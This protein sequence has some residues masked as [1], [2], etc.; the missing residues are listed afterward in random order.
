MLTSSGVITH[1]CVQIS[2]TAWL[3]GTQQKVCT[4]WRSSACFQKRSLSHGAL[5]QIEVTRAVGPGSALQGVAEA[6]AGVNEALAAARE[7]YRS[8]KL[9]MASRS[10]SARMARPLETHHEVV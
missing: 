8:N 3:C 6:P 10:D 1:T 9:F 7:D 2:T 5:L 4:A